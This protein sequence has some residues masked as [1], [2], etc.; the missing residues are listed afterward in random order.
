MKG[1]MIE[2]VPNR[3]DN[4]F[5]RYSEWKMIKR[6]IKKKRMRMIKE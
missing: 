1:R 4:A 3:V 2:L 5:C 6:K